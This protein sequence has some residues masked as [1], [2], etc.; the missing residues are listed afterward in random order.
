MADFNHFLGRAIEDTRGSTAYEMTRDRPYNGQLHTT[1]GLRGQQEVRGLTM[2]DIADC[3]VLGM[4]DASGRHLAPPTP[5]W[6][7]VYKCDFSHTDPIA[8]IKNATCWME[9][10]MGIY[11]NIPDEGTSTRKDGE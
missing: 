6:D 10:Y 3:I 2:R 7:D 8:I 9:K 1:A 11:P 5:I 4:L